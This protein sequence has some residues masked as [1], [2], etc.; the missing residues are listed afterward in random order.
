M[1]IDEKLSLLRAIESSGFS[2]S[3]SLRRLDVPRSTYYRWKAKFRKHGK[4]GL[5]DKK[6]TPLRQWNKLLPEERENILTLAHKNPELSSR[7][8][9]YQITD[10]GA[11]SV[12][13]STIYTVLKEEGLIRSQNIQSFPAGPEYKV[14]PTHVNEQWQT[15]ATYLLVKGWGWFYLISI[16]DDFSRKILA[17]ELMISMTGNDFSTV[18]ESACENVTKL[19]GEPIIMPRLVSDRGPA[20]I[21]HELGDYLEEKGIGHI[22]ASPY[23]PQTNGK[24][25]RFHKSIK[26]QINLMVWDSPDALKAEIGQFIKHYNSKRYHEA[27]GNVT[28]DDVFFGRRQSIIQKRKEVQRKTMEKRKTRNKNCNL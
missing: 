6:P 14:K 23:H 15:D 28:P 22:L 21:S 5:V 27:L 26:G 12:S 9:S 3:E 4:S 8:L 1:N 18:I 2:I 19:L 10:S 13:E 17:W 7:E 25:E 11:F 24:I 20:L 16:L